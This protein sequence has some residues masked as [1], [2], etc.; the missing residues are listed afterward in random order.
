MSFYLADEVRKDNVA[1][2]IMIPGHT[3]TTGFD[4]QNIARM[5]AGAT[6]AGPLPLVPEHMVPLGAAPGRSRREG[7][8]R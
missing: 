2:N 3:R 6:Q 5:K 4:E 8:H 7:A 1:V